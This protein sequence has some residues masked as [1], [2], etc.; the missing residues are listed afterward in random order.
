MLRRYEDEAQTP[1]EVAFYAD[2]REFLE[3]YRF[4]FNIILMDIELPHVDGMTAARKVR[5]KDP[6]VVIMFITNLAHYAI[7][8][9]EVN[10]VDFVL[11]PVSYVM[12]SLKMKNAIRL[13]ERS[14][15]T[16][17][18]LTVSNQTILV[19]TQDIYYVEVIK[20]NL[21]FHTAQGNIKQQGS[22]K[23]LEKQLQGEPFERCNNCYLVHLKYVTAVSKDTLVVSGDRLA[24]SRPRKK[25]FMESL[26]N[27]MGVVQ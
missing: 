24:I 26:T 5:E 6:E 16:K 17:L 10:A 13:V 4:Q 11:K 25:K 12:F 18:M 3:G 14:K 15:G 22:L 1:L 9:Y 8:G 19:G 27:Y 2:G 21:Y 7:N 20:H 23:E